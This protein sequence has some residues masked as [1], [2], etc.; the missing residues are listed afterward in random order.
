MKGQ[1]TMITAF[2]TEWAA[3]EMVASSS[4]TSLTIIRIGNPTKDFTLCLL[5][6]LFFWPQNPTASLWSFLF[7]PISNSNS[8]LLYLT[9]ESWMSWVLKEG[10]FT[11]YPGVTISERLQSQQST[12][13]RDRITPRIWWNLDCR[14]GM[15]KIKRSWQLLVLISAALLLW[16]CIYQDNYIDE[17]KQKFHKHALILETIISLN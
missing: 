15:I 12:P 7:T 17:E 8:N 11:P 13:D 2:K 6:P 10:K 9:T 5:K 16:L 3:S 14:S 4:R 1:I